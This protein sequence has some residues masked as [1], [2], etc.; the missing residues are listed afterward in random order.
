MPRPVPDMHLTLPPRPQVAQL[1]EARD[2]LQQQVAQLEASLSD[3]DTRK[4]V[5]LLQA[6]YDQVRQ[7]GMHS[8]PTG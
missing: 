5:E 3:V 1:S 7:L 6:Q 4:Q 2:R 8:V